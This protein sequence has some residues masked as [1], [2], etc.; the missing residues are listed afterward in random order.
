MCVLTIK[1]LTLS[2]LMH[3][4]WG[5]E[6]YWLDEGAGGNTVESSTEGRAIVPKPKPAMTP[7]PK[8]TPKP[9][10]RLKPRECLDP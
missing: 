4:R 2:H 10:P 6:W 8:A 1:M 5:I 7:A 9:A 3:G